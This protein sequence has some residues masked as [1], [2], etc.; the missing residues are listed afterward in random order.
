M[1]HDE[2]RWDSQFHGSQNMAALIPDAAHEYRDQV[3]AALREAYGV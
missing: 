1:P 2:R 3:N